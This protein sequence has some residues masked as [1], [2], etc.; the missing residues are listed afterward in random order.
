MVPDRHCHHHTEI[1]LVRTLR[2]VLFARCTYP[3]VLLTSFG[4]FGIGACEKI[5][6]DAAYQV[7]AFSAAQLRLFILRVPAG[8][9]CSFCALLIFHN[10]RHST[11]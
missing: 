9:V 7:T 3:I 6:V 4:M 11:S 1:V 10:L 5:R 2:V 8:A